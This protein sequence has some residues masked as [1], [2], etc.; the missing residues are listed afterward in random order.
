M[1]SGSV[2]KWLKSYI[3]NEYYIHNPIKKIH[4]KAKIPPILSDNPELYTGFRSFCVDNHHN[5]SSE[6]VQDY[7]LNKGLP[8]LVISMNAYYPITGQVMTESLL[9]Q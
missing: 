4:N 5:L 8:A 7:I 1:S 6:L 3:R 9:Q 2:Q